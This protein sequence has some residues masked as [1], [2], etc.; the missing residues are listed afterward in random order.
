MAVVQCTFQEENLCVLKKS[1]SCLITYSEIPENVNNSTFIG[2]HLEGKTNN[3]VNF[4]EFKKCIFSSKIPKDLTKVFPNLLGFEIL[5]SNLKELSRSD[6]EQ[7]K[8]LKMFCCTKTY[9][10]Y[11]PGD[12][13]NGFENLEWIDLGINDLE[14]IE[15]NILNGLDKL[16]MVSFS[17]NPN[18]EQFYSIFNNH[19]PN[20]TLDE[21]KTQL[22]EKFILSFKNLKESK[23]KL[24]IEKN[25]VDQKLKAAED[26]YEEIKNNEMSKNGFLGEI[27]SFI[28]DNSTKDFII[29]IDDQEFPAHRFILAARSPTLAEILE[30]NPEADELKLVDISVNIFEKI[31]KFLYTD[32]LPKCD[33]V[34]LNYLHLFAAT[35]Q[36]KIKNL[37]DYA[38]K[39]IIEQIN[40][41]NVIEILKLSNKY[42]HE[43]LRYKSFQKIKEKYPKI[44][45]IDD[46]QKDDDKILKIIEAFE[47]CEEAVKKAHEKF[48]SILIA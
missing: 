23:E 12:L 48:K 15:P 14:I 42:D 29:K 2:E 30:N 36:L 13:F 21:I 16:K 18:Y 34:E 27:N 17:K 38:A 31:L 8:T 37:K 44:P 45:F 43:E 33:D 4:I 40:E 19:A 35:G 5:N 9:L 1:Y 47:E 32:E 6:I 25:I 41:E 3:D 39:K 11:L 22:V 26:K 10:K 28:Q 46:W 7:F 20:A 24:E